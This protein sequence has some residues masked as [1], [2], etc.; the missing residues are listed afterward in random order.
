MLTR[1]LV[2]WHRDR[3]RAETAEAEVRRLQRMIE[4]LC[5]RISAAHDVIAKNAERRKQEEIFP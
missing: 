5:E 1:F 2:W 4:G 3:L